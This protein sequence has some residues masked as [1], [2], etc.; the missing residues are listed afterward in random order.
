[1]DSQLENY[2][3]EKGWQYKLVEGQRQVQVQNECPFCGKAKHLYFNAAT[4]KWD[5]KRC[6]ETGNLLTMKRRL[7][8]I[9]VEVRSASDYIFY[10]GPR[11]S[12][13][14]PGE[15]PPAGIDLK[16]HD[17]LMSGKAPDVLSYLKDVRGFTD[18]TLERFKIGVMGKGSKLFVSIPHYFDGE[19]I[20]VKFRS[21]PPAKK[22]FARWKDCPSVLFN[23]DCLKGL[24]KLKPNE[25]R[26]AVCEGEF[27]A[28]ALVQLGY[29][30]V[31]STTTGAGRSDWPAHW[32]APLDPAT[33]VYLCYDADEAGEE[34]AEKA[35]ATLGRFRCRRVVPPLKDWGECIAADLERTTVDECIKASREYDDSVVKPTT[36]FC[37]DLRAHIA[38]GQSRGRSTGWLTLDAVL[39]GIRDGELTVV[40]GDTGSGK[41]TFTTAL[42]RNQAMQNVPSLV[43]PFEQ[44]PHDVIGKLVS[45]EQ[46]KSVYDL[47]KIELEQGIADVCEWPYYFV[48]IHGTTPLGTI[49]DAIYVAVRKFGVRF[50]VLD[51][52]HFFLDCKPEEERTTIEAT[53][54]AMALW[55]Q[56]LMAHIV[57]VVHPKALGTD[58]NGNVRKPTIDH[59]KGSSGIKQTTWNVIRV[60]RMRQDTL[61][62]HDDDVEVSV[63]KCRSPAGSEGSIVLHFDR[64]GERYI[65]GT[66]TS[67]TPVAKDQDWSSWDQVQ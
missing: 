8:D 66:T 14:L 36:A 3:A 23:G 13:R 1:M 42:C 5:C 59:L 29:E 60:W 65:E 63:L 30:R 6:G 39:G 45:M 58:R 40:T 32:L 64:D 9:K 57:L 17:R 56:D 15:R 16:L 31:V 21:V 28:M 4:T 47:S 37:D 46:A 10:R 12:Q 7:G 11:D 19:L 67:G 52:L 38:G 35:A 55:V 54:R 22:F 27:D 44:R 33:T 18:T 25:R 41:T 24:D 43:A 49:K 48:N 62:A 2:L 61:G 34:G 50:I 26:V 20:C 51:H 53:M